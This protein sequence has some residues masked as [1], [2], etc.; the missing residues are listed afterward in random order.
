MT[1][2]AVYCALISKR[3]KNP[4]TKDDC[5]VEQHHI[6]PKSEGGLDEPD[7]LVNL[8]A[9]E[10]YIAHLLLAKIYKDFKMY[11][12]IRW[13]KIGQ[14]KLHKGQRGFRFNS[15]LF[16][17]MK[18]EY[19]N[20]NRGKVISMEAR[21]KMSLA[22]RG[23]K[24]SLESRQRMSIVRKG[25]R[26]YFTKGHSD[27]TREKIANSMRG[28]K[29]SFGQKIS[30]LKRGNKN[31]RGKQWWNNGIVEHRAFECPDGFVKGRLKR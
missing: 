20:R 10:H 3:L 8:T 22:K 6:I 1:Y 2:S 14:S 28:K 27:E 9:R 30:L 23:K 11:A 13:M 17:K 12:A 16:E 4:I 29:F 24:M 21:K 7:N 31:V 5:Y 15:R 19:D 25:H 26:P 18:L